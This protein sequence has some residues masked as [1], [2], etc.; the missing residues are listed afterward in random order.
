LATETRPSATTRQ[1]F[2]SRRP[3]TNRKT[4]AWRGE[5]NLRV[6]ARRILR[7]S[8]ATCIGIVA[9]R[10]PTGD[11]PGGGACA[12][13]LKEQAVKC[14]SCAARWTATVRLIRWERLTPTVGHRQRG[15]FATR[16]S[17][18]LCALISIRQLKTITTEA[19]AVVGRRLRLLRARLD[20]QSARL[21]ACNGNRTP[22]DYAVGCT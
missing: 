2:R 11:R 7:R 20:C 3:T 19:E 21:I 17:Q 14:P 13:P 1:R 5:N 12:N 8:V 9:G 4:S 16:V 18:P 15:E 22:C 10:P 6:R